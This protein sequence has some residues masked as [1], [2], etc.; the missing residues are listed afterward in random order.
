MLFGSP[1]VLGRF[2]CRLNRFAAL[3]KVGGREERVH[4]RNSGRLR[5]LFTPAQAVLL[6]QGPR[7]LAGSGGADSAGGAQGG[8]RGSL[9]R[10]RC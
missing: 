3:V 1:L 5:E 8:E 6:E 9:R 4:V 7:R 2:L 10:P